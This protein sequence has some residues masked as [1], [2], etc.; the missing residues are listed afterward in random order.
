MSSIRRFV[1]ASLLVI[2]TLNFAPNTAF[3]QEPARG[4]FTLTHGVQWGNAKVPA[5][6]Y[7][8][9]FAPNGV[10]GVLM[11]SELDGPRKSYMVLVHDTEETKPSDLSRLVLNATPD[12]SYVSAMQLPE[13]GMTLYFAVPSRTSEKQIAGTVTTARASGQ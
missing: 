11:V 7:R 5:G 6:E 2:T 4:R 13:F 3:G 8:F 10:M 1:Y 12:G 9:S